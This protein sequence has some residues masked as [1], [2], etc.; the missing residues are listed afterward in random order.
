MKTHQLNKDVVSYCDSSPKK[1]VTTFLM[2]FR[3]YLMKEH[4]GWLDFYRNN[5]SYETPTKINL[6]EKFGSRVS[7]MCLGEESQTKTV[8]RQ[9]DRCSCAAQQ[10]LTHTNVGSLL[11]LPKFVLMKPYK[12]LMF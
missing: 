4:W 7:P 11:R 9:S 2:M 12:V 3:E 6:S 5:F 10:T 1:R 8:F